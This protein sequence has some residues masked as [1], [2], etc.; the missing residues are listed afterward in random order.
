MIDAGES[1]R[2]PTSEPLGR[3]LVFTAKELREAFVETLAAAG[4][5]LGVWVV[6]SAVSDEGEVSQAALADHAHL[7][8]ATIT[9]HVDRLEALGLVTR[10]LDPEDRRVRRVRLTAEGEALNARLVSAVREFE[11]SSMAGLGQRKRAELQRALER[12]RANLR[13]RPGA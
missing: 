4:G 11:A 2:A 1:E 5:S 8:A 12:I 13:E 9:H 10:E 6:L 7:E 3:T